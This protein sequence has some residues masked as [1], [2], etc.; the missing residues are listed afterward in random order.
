MCHQNLGS[1]GGTIFCM[2]GA[3]SPGHLTPMPVAVPASVIEQQHPMQAYMQDAVKPAS[4]AHEADRERE[5]TQQL[6]L[7][8]FSR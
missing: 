3:T 2:G 6:A 4:W 5:A 1:E 8:I 7:K